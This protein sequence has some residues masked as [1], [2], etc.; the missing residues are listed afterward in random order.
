MNRR[1]PSSLVSV[2]TLFVLATAARAAPTPASGTL[3]ATQAT[4]LTWQGGIAAGANAAT[5]ESNC[6]EGT[7]C[8]AFTLTVAG[9]PSDWNGKFANVAL[10]WKVA[11][12]EYDLYVHQGSLTGPVVAVSNSGP[13][14]TSNAV[15][16]DVSNPLIGTGVFVVHAVSSQSAIADQYTGSAAVVARPQKPA[17]A[18]QATGKAPRFQI[19]NPSQAQIAAGFGTAAGEPSIGANWNT[20]AILFQNDLNT[21][22]VTVDESCRSSPVPTWTE[23]S[24]PFTNKTSLD[25]I[26]FTDVR[27]GRTQVSQ[28]AG[29]TSLSAYSDDDGAT[30]IPSQGGG[31]PSGVDHQTVGGGPFHAPL[32]SG[33]V[34]S[35]AVYYC[36]QA[37]AEANCSLSLNGGL[38][39]GPAVPIYNLT[40]CNGLHGHIKVGPDGTAY[41]PNDNC[42]SAG[43]QAVVVSEDNGI[44]WNVRGI[45]N[46][47][48]GT[49]DPAVASDRGGTLYFAYAD[50]DAH[51]VVAIST[52]HGRTFGKLVDVGA[53]QGIQAVEFSE[54]VAGDP[55]RAA[56]MFLG[57]KTSGNPQDAH[58]AGL[59]H[60]YVAVTYDGGNSWFTQDATPNDP[61]QRGPIWNGGGAVVY[62]NLL[63]FNDLT[64]D[65]KGRLVASFADGCFD[66]GCVQGKG[67]GNGYTAIAS[68]LQQV[69][70]KSLL[71]IYD[72]LNVDTEPGVPQLKVLRNGGNAYL[73]W[74]ESNDGGEPVSNYAVYRG[75]ASGAETFLANA[76]RAT[77]FVDPTASANT[78][79]FY[80][81]IATNARGTSCGNDEVRSV[82]AGGSC[83]AGGQIVGSFAPGAQTGA[84]ANLGL[85]VLSLGVGEPAFP[86]GVGRLVFTMKVASLSSLPP[87]SQWRILWTTP[88]APQEFWYVGMNSDAQGHVTYEYGTYGITSV[89]ATGVGMYSTLGPP[90]FGSYSAD[91]TITIGIATNLVGDPGAG[92]LLGAV[93]GKAY[94][95]TGPASKEP[96]DVGYGGTYLVQGAG[97][98]H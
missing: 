28:L 41:V 96:I 56:M 40:Q 63:D 90:D 79:Y 62:R 52:D 78:T 1:P 95:V 98:C 75:L 24:S 17:P 47:S 15:N 77:S 80:R 16:L 7:T 38:T 26:L 31:I 14:V 89:V 86:D 73:S 57:S 22:K 8:E 48:V 93:T 50:A 43:T 32:P 76:G 13:G 88:S 72:N 6:V 91:G 30:W 20:G 36:T 81:V 55:G 2:V 23:V 35:D 84:P 9:A 61:V 29:E 19:F 11:A 82:P 25:P 64:I 21:Y 27:T 58:F 74:N 94:L 87:D 4:P 67:S 54:M 69:G 92:D 68:V 18:L 70:G 39:F 10:T 85:D 71:G 5:G 37:I 49:S 33:A 66:A 44:T 65:A 60:L 53:S 12:V 51:P 97:Y 59:W 42:P 34:Y 83:L 46:S 45:P 3:S